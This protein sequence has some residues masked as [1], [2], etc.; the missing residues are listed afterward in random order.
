MG[1]RARSSGTGRRGRET[2][3]RG[4]SRE[5][6]MSIATVDQR[7]LAADVTLVRVR[8]LRASVRA[9]LDCA[10]DAF[11]VPPPSGRAATKII[12]AAAGEL[13]GAFAGPR[14]I[15]D[16]VDERALGAHA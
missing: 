6:D 12:G 16:V 11:A 9:M 3:D 5:R 8:D 15:A 2:M 1:I 14:R 4:A 13:L 7:V 10:D